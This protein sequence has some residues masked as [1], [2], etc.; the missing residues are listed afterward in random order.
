MQRKS[1]IALVLCAASAGVLAGCFDLKPVRVDVVGGDAVD[2]MVVEDQHTVRDGTNGAD[3]ADGADVTVPDA[4]DGAV[5]EQDVPDALS[6]VDVV[7]VPNV[8]D[9]PNVMDVPNAVDIPT[10]LDTG[11]CPMGTVVCGGAG[12]V[13]T[14]TSSAHCG[15]C[16]NVCVVP[17]NGRNSC[18]AGVCQPGCNAGFHLV[19]NRCVQNMAVPRLLSPMSLGDVDQRLP[20]LS[21]QL[22]ADYDGSEVQLCRDRACTMV[23]ETI[24]TN[25]TNVV[26][27]MQ[28]PV[29]SVV[30]WRV[31]GRVGNATDT[32]A[33]AT[34]LFHVTSLN[35]VGM[36]STSVNPHLDVNGDGFDDVAIGVPR[37]T[38]AGAALAG[39][40]RLVMGQANAAN[41]PFIPNIIRSGTAAG[42]GFGGSVASAGDVNGDG[43]GDLIVGSSQDVGGAIGAGKVTIYHGSMGGL[44]AMPAQVLLGDAVQQRFGFSV[45]T[46][47][48]IDADG[49]ADVLIGVERASRGVATA[50]EVQVFHGSASGIGAVLTTRIAGTEAGGRF[51]CSVASAGDVNRD[52]F[53][54]VIIG[55]S[56]SPVATRS[57]AAFV[58][59]GSVMG[60]ANMPTQ[61]FVGE[62]ANHGYGTSVSGGGDVN[63]D[64]FSDVI[65]GAPFA[66][67]NGHA[68]SGQ[69]YVYSGANGPLVPWRV[70]GGTN[71]ND[72]FGIAVAMVGDLNGDGFGD[73]VVG[74]DLGDSMTPNVGTMS[75]F[76]GVANPVAGQAPVAEGQNLG[77]GARFGASVVGGM[78]VNR[79]GYFDV[80]VGAPGAN[81]RGIAATGTASLYLGT[82]AAHA[83]FVFQLLEF[84]PV[85][86][87]EGNN[88]GEQ[89]G[90]SVAWL[91][92]WLSP[93]RARSLS[94]MSI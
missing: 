39:E 14:Q 85:Q 16:G 84:A 23:I 62:G 18:S 56:Q 24:Q 70:Y 52:G 69:A 5:M 21:W 75:I 58:Y 74:A 68:T 42:E 67:S 57:G 59:N 30:F 40:V 93:S 55:A 20:S 89:F 81:P 65:V 82:P 7:D 25:N 73:M 48:D 77:A 45:A 8:L 32:N 54:D 13:N 63:G 37:A 88:A 44:S 47:G 38:V 29:R 35:R 94:I 28:L 15:M 60:L 2:G 76:R 50:G 91:A 92:P 19:G 86:M 31:R 49:Y 17:M 34:W 79:D 33:S 3:V 41:L 72:Q 71:L 6:P 10:P 61:T 1:D 64:G 87:F 66:P 78:D 90:A 53:S 4:Q 27:T 46:A 43:F 12:C 11:V 80:V 22:P 83:I 51:G 9:V 26:P 36:R